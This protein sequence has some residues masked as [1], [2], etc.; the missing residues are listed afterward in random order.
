MHTFSESLAYLRDRIWGFPLILLILGA[1]LFLTIRLR[2]VQ[3]RYLKQALR[4]VVAAPE[5]NVQ[6]DISHF[7]ALMTA[8]AAT[9]G[10]GNIAGVAIAVAVGGLGALFW[11]VVAALI[12]MATIYSEAFLAVRFRVRDKR[13]EMAGGP[14]YTIRHGQGWKVVAVLFAGAGSIAALTTGNMVQA[15]SIADVIEYLMPVNRWLIGLGTAV[16]VGL[17]LLG[18]IRNIGRVAS[19]L[20]P[21]MA[22]FYLVGGLIILAIQWHQLPGALMTIVMA[23]FKPAAVGGGATGLTILM[24]LRMGV[25]RGL[26]ASE[27]GL[28]S[29]PIA[30]AAAKTNQPARQALISMTGAFLSVCVVCTITGLVLAVTGVLGTSGPNGQVLTGVPL[31]IAAF[32]SVLPFGHLI[33]IVGAILFGYSTIL[34]WAYYG[35]KCSEYLFGERAIR[36]YRILFTLMVVV[37]AVLELDVVWSLADI[38]NA[39]MVVPNLIGV[40]ALSGIVARETTPYLKLVRAGATI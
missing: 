17:V 16:L 10:I 19:V 9:I 25:A 14:M 39:F 35:E 11:M 27:A 13:G 18:G 3:F 2:G 7:Q 37:G 20:V 22:L 5:K 38:S 29:S 4:L 26:L 28:G 30:A 1:G 34:G 31:T 40:L 6:G 23:A 21:V 33:V 36:S 32:D 24:T 12:G 15:N 8:L